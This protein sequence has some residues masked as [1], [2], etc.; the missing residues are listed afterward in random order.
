MKKLISLLTLVLV[1]TIS[2]Q[3]TNAQQLPSL[4]PNTIGIMPF[5]ATINGLGIGAYYERNLNPEGTVAF[6]FPIK[7]NFDEF[8]NGND[9]IM[10]P[11]VDFSP[12]IK[13]YPIRRRVIEFAV[14]PSLFYTYGKADGIKAIYEPQGSREVSYEAIQ[15]NLGVLGTS[16]LNIILAKDFIMS[17]EWGVGLN[18]IN[19]NIEKERSGAKTV[20]TYNFGFWTQTSI[21]FA[22]RF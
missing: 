9:H 11:N 22:Y 16:Y 13:F 12:G 6:H 19:K 1:F 14:G 4:K 17:V 20:Y 7:I 2:G 21:G 3:I 18:Y 10:R 15:H 5:T 8:N